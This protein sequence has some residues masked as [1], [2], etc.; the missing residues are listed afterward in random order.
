MHLY[1]HG[2]IEGNF[3]SSQLHDPW[4]RLGVM[5]SVDFLPLSLCIFSG[6]SGFFISQ[7]HASRWIG[8]IDLPLEVNVYGHGPGCIP[9]AC[10]GFASGSTTTLT[11]IKMNGFITSTL[12]KINFE[13]INLLTWQRNC[14]TTNY[15]K[16]LEH[17][18][19]LLSSF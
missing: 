7:K 18:N 3:A 17:D 11:R 12:L 2:S 5:V 9:T 15:I 4:V 13:N 8:Y 6:S 19:P 10:Q 1:W 14:Y 16:M